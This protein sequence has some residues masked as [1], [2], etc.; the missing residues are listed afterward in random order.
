LLVVNAGV[1]V[2]TTVDV[3][4]FGNVVEKTVVVTVIGLVDDKG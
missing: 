2:G 3:E 4:T 1:E